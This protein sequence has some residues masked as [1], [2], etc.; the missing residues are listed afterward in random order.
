MSLIRVPIYPTRN[1]ATEIDPGAR[2]IVAGTNINFVTNPDGSITL[3]V[4]TIGTGTVTSVG[5]TGSTGLTVG[6]TNPITT[7]GT[8]TFT[9]SANLQSWSGIAPSS[10]ADTSDLANYVTLATAQN[11]SG[12]KVFTNGAV[13]IQG[14]SGDPTGGVLYLG[15]AA[16]DAYIYRPGSTQQLLFKYGTGTATLDSAGTIWTTGNFTPGNYVL[17]TG[18]TMSGTLTLTGAGLFVNGVAQIATGST[19]VAQIGAWPINANYVAYTNTGMGG[20]EYVFLTANPA[21]DSST[22]ISSG[23]GGVVSIRPSA[24]SVT[25]QVTFSTSNV[26]SAVP[27]I[28]STGFDVRRIAPVVLN[29][30]QNLD[31]SHLNKVVEK[32]NTSNYTYTIPSGLGAHGDCITILNGNNTGTITIARGGGVSLY[33]NGLDANITVN[34]GNMVTIMRTSNTDRW[35]A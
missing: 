8:L 30:T 31:S 4:P 6:G 15:D 23:T 17:K 32:S 29:N 13:R 25:G 27:Y 34:P 24:N 35:Q 22:Y 14:W 11:I 26:T 10:K 12:S 7:S 3:N 18:D 21:I 16:T 2:T 5:A 28:D 1:L 19:S 33:R 9:L 20:S